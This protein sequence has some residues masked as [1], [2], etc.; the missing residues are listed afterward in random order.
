MLPVSHVAKD[1]QAKYGFVFVADTPFDDPETTKRLLE[2]IA[3]IRVTHYGGFYDFTP[4]LAMADTAYTNFALPAHTDNTYFTDPA[5]LQAFHLL[6]HRPPPGTSS[7]APVSGGE[8]LLVDGFHAARLLE[9]EDPTAYKI[10]STVRL[11]WHASGNKGITIAP[12]R[13]Y[14]VLELDEDTGGLHRVRWNNDDRGVVPFGEHYS[15]TDWYDAAR[16]WDAILRRKDVEFWT[17]LLPGRPLSML[18]QLGIILPSSA[19]LRRAQLICVFLVPVFDNWR[20]L[21]GRSAFQGIRRICGAYSQFLTIYLFE[22]VFVLIYFFSA[23]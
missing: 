5:G 21:H 19:C 22:P 13:R 8:S 18:S 3:F 2:R 6:S 15:P 17:Q 1:C 9:A 12:D 20:V 16:K 10:L 7:D 11:P 4:D 23:S 14:P